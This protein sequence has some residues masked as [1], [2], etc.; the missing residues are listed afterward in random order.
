[1]ITET[2]INQF[3][4]WLTDNFYE[5][6]FKVS[7]TFSIGKKY[8][9]IIR[10]YSNGQRVVYAFL[11]FEG[12]IYMPACWSRPAKHVRGHISSPEL[13]CGRYGVK[14]INENLNIK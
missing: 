13:C 12:N 2:E 6:P 4:S 7:Y 8:I 1:M 3:I 9:K 5:V 14:Y 10:H 11:D